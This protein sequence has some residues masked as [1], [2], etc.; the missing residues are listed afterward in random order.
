MSAK[1]LVSAGRGLEPIRNPL[2]PDPSPGKRGEGSRFSDRFLVLLAVG[3]LAAAGLVREVHAAR[4]PSAKLLPE[5]TA[6]LLSVADVRDL[7]QRFMN[8]AMGRMSRDPQMRPFV[9]HLYASLAE[10]VASVEDRIGLSLPELLAIPQ[11]E[12]TLALIAP[13]DAPP[14]FLF[15]LDA[16]SH[17]SGA[18]ELLRRGT[19]AL[20]QSGADRSEQ[21]VAG[22]KFVVYDGVGR[23]NRTLAYF[24][25]DGAIVVGSNVGMLTEFLARWNGEKG[26]TLADNRRFAAVMRQCRGAEGEPPQ[27]IWYADPILLMQSI[28]QENAGVRIAV[29]MLPTL[30]LDGLQGVGG[31]LAMD[32][33]QFDSI[34]HTHL[35][36]DN[37]RTRVL[38][39][40]ALDSGD[41]QPESWVPGD[42]ASY[43]T[44]H[45]KIDKTYKTLTDLVDGFRGEGALSR[46]LQR[47]IKDR[48]GLDLEK[49]LLPA[50]AG[51]ITHVTWVERPV[52]P[53]SQRTLVAFKLNDAASVA[54]VLEKL[55]RQN[56]QYVTRQTYVGKEYYTFVPPQRGDRPPNPRA[57]VPCFGIVEDCLVIADRPSIIEKALLTARDPS[58]SLAE[59]LDFKLIASKI[60]RRCGGTKPAMITFTRPE[61]GMR[62]LYEMAVADQSR[63]QLRKRAQRNP[64]FKTLNTALETNPL[65]PFAVLQRYLA[66]E[67]AMVVDDQNGIHYMGFT[68]RRN[69]EP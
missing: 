50:L 9:D 47:R 62:I 59:A 35:L 51:R 28:A 58:N 29:A 15:L 37:P 60:R 66:P 43:A 20:D 36:L 10:A 52:T 65:P 30:G 19:E 48:I 44:L 67:G 33:G 31:S 69:P 64:L 8:T 22:T 61:E 53:T 32:V 39:L 12:I 68:L 26:T 18:R 54:G 38:E 16:G 11:G 14:D 34:A 21:R 2:T 57:P 55:S 56:Q 40:L 25:K 7:S 41:M 49:D 6:V 27:L 1:L 3:V 23:R 4:P 17:V 63:E 46:L 42:A 24:E 45:W 13:K 5:R